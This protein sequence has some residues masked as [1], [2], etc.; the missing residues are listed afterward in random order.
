MPS[1]TQ[2][3]VCGSSA[4]LSEAALW[5]LKE[6]FDAFGEDP[7]TD[8]DELVGRRAKAIVIQRAIQSGARA[9]EIADQIDKL[10]S[11]PVAA[12]ASKTAKAKPVNDEFDF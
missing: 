2:A 1:S 9:G 10:M 12:K 5:K 7:S 3:V 11:A 4:S 8:T 6:T